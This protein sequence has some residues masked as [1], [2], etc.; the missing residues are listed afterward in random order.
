MTTTAREQEGKISGELNPA[1]LLVEHVD[2]FTEIKAERPIL[3]LAC[4]DGHNGIFLAARGF[5]V[6]LADRSEE[7]LE[8]ARRL[9]D[10]HGVAVRFWQVDLEREGV[11][12]LEEDEYAGIIVFRYL[13]RPLIPCIRKALAGGGLLVYETFTVDQPRFGKPHNP[14]FLLKP[15][16]LRGWFAD[17]TILHHFEG[18]LQDPPRAVAQ[19]VCRKP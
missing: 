11:N 13:H 2:L 6:V 9:A 17:W 4:G 8:R 7:A 15:G 18:I 16:E 10:Q 1:A 19:I 14:A 12:P 5:Q 3:D